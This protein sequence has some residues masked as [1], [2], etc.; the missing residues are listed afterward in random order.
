MLSRDLPPFFGVRYYT[1]LGNSKIWEAVDSIFPESFQEASAIPGPI[2][3]R[4][5]GPLYLP[6]SSPSSD[7][8]KDRKQITNHLLDMLVS[9]KV[10]GQGRDQAL[11]L[12]SKNV[13][14]KDLAIHDNS[15]TIYVVDNGEEVGGSGAHASLSSGHQG[16]RQPADGGRGAA[17]VWEKS[18]FPTEKPGKVISILGSTSGLVKV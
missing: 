8:K 5:P 11:N 3:L 13:P 4:R 17:L 9:K 16:T 15:H 10:S 1:F 14:R 6:L 12:L 7:T 18:S 2:Y